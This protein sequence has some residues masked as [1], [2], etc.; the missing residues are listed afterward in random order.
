MERKSFDLVEKMGKPVIDLIPL[1]AA[2]YK[3]PEASATPKAS[4]APKAST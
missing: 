3:P 1:C 4:A 2:D